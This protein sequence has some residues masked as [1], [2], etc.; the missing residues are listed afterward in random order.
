VGRF[1]DHVV[2]LIMLSASLIPFLIIYIVG[3]VLAIKRMRDNPTRSRIAVAAFSMFAV[4]L[5]MSIA[6]N[7]LVLQRDA[8]GW[9]ANSRVVFMGILGVVDV[10]L[11]IA[12]WTVLLVALFRRFETLESPGSHSEEIPQIETQGGR[13]SSG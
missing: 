10:Q 13:A 2:L 12:A 4:R 7:S 11:G 8:L 3:F 1:V 9:D 5:F 6:K